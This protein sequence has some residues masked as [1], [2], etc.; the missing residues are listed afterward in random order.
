MTS[1]VKVEIYSSIDV[2]FM[3]TRYDQ[4]NKRQLMKT[5]GMIQVPDGQLV[6]KISF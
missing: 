2:A 6:L 5:T 4:S 1:H 3:Y